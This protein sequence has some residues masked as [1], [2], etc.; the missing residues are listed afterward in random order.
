MG[1]FEVNLGFLTFQTHEQKYS[2]VGRGPS[3]GSIVCRP[4]NE[5]E[6]ERNTIQD[7]KSGRCIKSELWLVDRVHKGYLGS[8]LIG[9]NKLTL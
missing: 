4:H 5:A 2:S 6:R 8:A 9:E 1:V 3:R 7:E